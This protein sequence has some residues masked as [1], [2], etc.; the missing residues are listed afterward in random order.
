MQLPTGAQ[1]N[2]DTSSER[3][4]QRRMYRVRKNRVDMDDIAYPQ[5][6]AQGALKARS[7]GESVGTKRPLP[8]QQ[9]A[10]GQFGESLAVPDALIRG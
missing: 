7:I 3:F 10:F 5:V 8:F 4:A 6:G 2:R 9:D 1:H